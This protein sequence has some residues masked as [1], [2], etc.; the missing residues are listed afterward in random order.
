MTL[1]KM[2]IIGITG[3]IGSGKSCVLQYLAEKEGVYIIEADR[4]AEELMNKGKSIYTAIVK[5]FGD[6][7]LDEEGSIDRAKLAGIVF[8]DPESLKLLNSLTHPAVK[9]EI[10]SRIDMAEDGFLKNDRR[11]EIKLFIIEAA[12]LIEDGYKEICN[13]MCYVFAERDV[14]IKRL[15]AG[16]GYTREIC[17]AIMNNQKDDSFYLDNSDVVID[18]SNDFSITERLIEDIY[19]KYFTNC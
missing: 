2:K 8:N 15:I 11:E 18:N 7:I 1:N 10:L 4:L 12:L 5:S 6:D 3:G 9:K 16:R 13:M 14:R 19:K 17:L